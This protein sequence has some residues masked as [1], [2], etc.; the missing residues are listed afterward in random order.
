M[1]FLCD[2]NRKHSQELPILSELSAAYLLSLM[3]SRSATHHASSAH[4]SHPV[5]LPHVARL[6]LHEHCTPTPSSFWTDFTSSSSPELSN[7][8]AELHAPRLLRLSSVPPPPE[9]RTDAAHVP[10][11][12][13]LCCH[14][15]PQL[16]PDIRHYPT[17]ACLAVVP[18]TETQY[19]C[20]IRVARFH[21]TQIRAGRP[22]IG[23][24]SPLY[25]R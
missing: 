1:W 19:G 21:E 22:T 7:P 20:S 24:R 10:R 3:R 15:R 2:P 5:T 16:Q 12:I 4:A 17:V 13:A 23:F 11:P 18:P 25:W 6:T 8:T 9:L 14:A